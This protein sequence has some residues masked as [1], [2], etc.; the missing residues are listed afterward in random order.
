VNVRGEVHA[1]L[2]PE[3]YRRLKLEAAARQVSLSLCVAQCLGEYFSLRQEMATA[4]E[5]EVPEQLETLAP[6]RVIHVL[7]AQTEQRLVATFER[8]MDDLV[9]LRGS[10]DALLAM[11]DCAAF[12]ALGQTPDVPLPA[13]DRM[14]ASDP[15]RFAHWRQAVTRMLLASG[16]PVPWPLEDH[17]RASPHGGPQGAARVAS[18]NPGAPPQPLPT[19]RPTEQHGLQRPKST[20]PPGR[21][22]HEGLPGTPD[23]SDPPLDLAPG[24]VGLRA[25]LTRLVGWSR[26]SESPR[27]T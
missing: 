9:A 1:Y 11:A 7:L 27:R 23:S 24:D 10:V 21:P 8:Y 26:A 13:R 3:H 16:R 12:L 2:P 25:R 5:A 20:A 19:G 18:D 4:L 14:L 22:T 15:R 6:S 17:P